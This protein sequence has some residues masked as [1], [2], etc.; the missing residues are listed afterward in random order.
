M[1][2]AGGFRPSPT[3]RPLPI[4]LTVTL[5]LIAG[6]GCFASKEAGKA[7]PSD[8]RHKLVVN[9]TTTRDAEK[10][11]GA[12]AVKTGADAQERWT[13]EHTRVSARRLNPFGRG[14]TVQQTPYERLVLTFQRGVL[15]D[16][17]YVVERYR[18][19]GEL[20]VPD[21]TAHDACGAKK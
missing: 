3:S 19:E 10:L 14:M 20:I 16:C 18:T 1:T 11:L 7:F 15:S 5:A 9:Q 13:Y 12:P 8:A 17:A 21:G 4:V 2:P 6:A